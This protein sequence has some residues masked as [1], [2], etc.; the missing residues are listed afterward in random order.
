MNNTTAEFGIWWNGTDIV[1]L[2][3]LREPH[4]FEEIPDIPRKGETLEDVGTWN[5]EDLK[6]A[7]ELIKIFDM[8]HNHIYANEFTQRESF[9]RDAEIHFHEND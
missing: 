4:K 9:Q 7:T 5:K 8:I 1:Y 2:H 6:P 3:R